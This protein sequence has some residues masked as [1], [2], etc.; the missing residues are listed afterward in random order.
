MKILFILNGGY[1]NKLENFLNDYDIVVAVDLGRQGD[2]VGRGPARLEEVLEPVSVAYERGFD[3]QT[4]LVY[5][6]TAFLVVILVIERS[7]HLRA[8]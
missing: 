6:D 5:S 4:V 1:N 2:G 3:T 7:V 8:P